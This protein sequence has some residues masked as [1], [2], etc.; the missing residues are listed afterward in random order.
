MSSTHFFEDLP[1]ISEE[2]NSFYSKIFLVEGDI[3]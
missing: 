2:I 1:D 3:F